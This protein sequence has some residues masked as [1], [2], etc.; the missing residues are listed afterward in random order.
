MKIK[1]KGA[2]FV[3]VV[4]IVLIV[5]ILVVTGRE[6]KNNENPNGQ[7]NGNNITEEFVKVSEDG[8]KVNTSEQL[9]KT[10]IVAGL[11]LTNISLTENGGLTQL[12]AD[13]KNTTNSTIEELD[14]IITAIDKNGNA[15]AEFEGSVYGLAAGQTT[16]LNAAITADIANAY[17]FTVKEK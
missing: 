5:V 10:K 14:I 15:L 4:A 9:K 16:T 6:E 13:A 8:S 11:E 7:A 1:S 2:F 12:L 17:D 3:C